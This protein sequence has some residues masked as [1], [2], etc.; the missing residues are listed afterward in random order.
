MFFSFI[1]ILL[2]N[3]FL[4]TLKAATP[5]DTVA[6]EMVGRSNTRKIGF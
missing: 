4:E 2:T 3:Q 6:V 1:Y 5:Q